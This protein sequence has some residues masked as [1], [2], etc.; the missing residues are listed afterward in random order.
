MA[1]GVDVATAVPLALRM[2][3]VADR[4]VAVVLPEVCVTEPLAWTV[5]PASYA[6]LSVV[7][8]AAICVAGVIVN[9]ALLEVMNAP[10]CRNVATA[11]TPVFQLYVSVTEPFGRTAGAPSVTL[12]LAGGCWNRVAAGIVWKPCPGGAHCR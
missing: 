6:L 11:V 4:F 8:A 2:L 5:L 1:S 12:A 9:G 3:I 10:Y 7:T